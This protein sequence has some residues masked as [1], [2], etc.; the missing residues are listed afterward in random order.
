MMLK[1]NGNLELKINWACVLRGDVAD[2]QQLVKLIQENLGDCVVVYATSSASRLFI[3]EG[4]G[5]CEK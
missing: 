2:V 5:R 1:M 3:Q 4:G